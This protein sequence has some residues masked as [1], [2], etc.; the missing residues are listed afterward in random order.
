MKRIQDF[1]NIKPIN[2]YPKIIPGGYVCRITV[3]KDYFEY[4]YLKIE[5][6]FAEGELRGFYLNLFLSKG[7]WGG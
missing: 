6:D 1:K 2:E 5:Y 4:E 3:V 7:F